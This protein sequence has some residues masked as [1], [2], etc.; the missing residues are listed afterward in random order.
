[1]AREFKALNITITMEK[2]NNEQERSR[3]VSAFLKRILS[4]ACAALNARTNMILYLGVK[5]D[6]TITGIQIND[7]SLVSIGWV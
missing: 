3:L 1:M 6:G 2:W 5:D 4:N 7:P